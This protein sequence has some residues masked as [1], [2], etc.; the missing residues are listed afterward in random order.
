MPELVSLSVSEPEEQDGVKMRR[1]TAIV[2]YYDWDDEN[3][4]SFLCADRWEDV[5]LVRGEEQREEVGAHV[6]VA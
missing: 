3:E 4:R 2:E 1:L 5:E 6:H